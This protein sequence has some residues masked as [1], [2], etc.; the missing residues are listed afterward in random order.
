MVIAIVVMGL[1]SG[2]T[3][4]FV[5]QTIAKHHAL[6]L[7]IDKFIIKLNN[8]CSRHK[9]PKNTLSYPRPQSI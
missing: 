5:M 2:G 3:Q 4:K 1:T 8:F 7:D 9:T 6:C